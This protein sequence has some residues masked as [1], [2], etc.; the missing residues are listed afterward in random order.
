MKISTMMKSVVAA[1]AVATVPVTVAP[2]AVAAYPI[3]GPMGSTLQE[4][5]TVGQVVFS[6]NVG[7]LRPSSDTMPDYPVAGKVWEATATVHAI[8]G[9]VTPAISQFN[10]VA[11]NQ[12]VYRVLWEVASPKGISGATIPE[13]A[14]SSGKIYFDVTGAAPTTVTMNNGMEDLMIWTP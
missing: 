1:V 13:G 3:T 4:T 7:D 11:P 5:D 2:T 14:Q 12:T 10:A 6:W 8:H 9:P